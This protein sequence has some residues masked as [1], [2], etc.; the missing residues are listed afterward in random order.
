MLADSLRAIE[1][2]PGGIT[3]P[4]LMALAMAELSMD[5]IDAGR[6]HLRE[7]AV[8]AVAVGDVSFLDSWWSA[9][10]SRLAGATDNEMVAIIEQVIGL[11]EPGSR[12]RATALG[13]LPVE[14]SVGSDMRRAHQVGARALAIARRLDDPALLRQIVHTWHLAA[15]VEVPAAE[16]R[17]VV[18]KTLALRAPAGKRAADVLGWVTLAGDCLQLGDAGAA[19]GAVDAA[20]AATAGFGAT[21]LRWVALRSEVMLATKDGRLEHA[22]TVGEQAANMAASMP[23]PDTPSI[24]VMQLILIRYHQ[25][26]L[27]EV[28]PFMAAVGR[29]CS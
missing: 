16:R 19:A 17:V 9:V 11:T 7:A 13:W 21:H 1:H 18:E 6:R 20:L 23:W 14:L 2:A 25:E 15:R 5:H 24:Q 12:R 10:S 28:Q 27:H 8:T 3:A 4:L 26:R 29:G 22:E